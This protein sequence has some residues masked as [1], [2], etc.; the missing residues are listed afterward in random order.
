[1]DSVHAYG[2]RIRRIDFA[3]GLPELLRRIAWC[4]PAYCWI[5]NDVSN[6]SV[7]FPPL[8]VKHVFVSMAMKVKPSCGHGPDTHQYIH[9]EAGE[10]CIGCSRRRV[11]PCG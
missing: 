8:G 7:F 2:K 9:S 3:Y 5:A 10:G 1:M 11:Q 6:M 4:R